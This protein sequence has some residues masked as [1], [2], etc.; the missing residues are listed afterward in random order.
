MTYIDSIKANFSS[1]TEERKLLF[2]PLI[3][4][5][6][7]KKEQ[8]KN[9]DLILICTHNSRRSHFAQIWAQIAA[10]YYGLSFVTTFSGGTEATA[11]NPRAVKAL[12]TIGLQIGV[13]DCS[14]PNPIYTIQRENG[15]TMNAFS[16]AFDHDTNPQQKFAAVMTC[17]HADENCPFVP[18]AEV[19]IPLYYQ[20]PKESDDTAEESKT[21]AARSLQIATEF[22][23]IFSQ[24]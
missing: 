5:I 10:D 22:F 2:S 12:Q 24:V 13:D 20:D 9:C 4:Y 15:K 7:Q 14:K 8:D 19:R 3:K 6:K 1:I 16:K 18:G 23:Y 17:D 21:Y 11:F